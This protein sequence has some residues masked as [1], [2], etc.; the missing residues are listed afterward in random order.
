MAGRLRKRPGETRARR[1]W[2]PAFLRSLAAGSS[3][4][5]AAS[6]VGISRQEVYRMRREEPEFATD[7]DDAREEGADTLEDVAYQRAT[8]GGSDLLLI[9]LLKA[10][11]P[12]IYREQV[13]VEGGVSH[14]HYLPQLD[15]ML[16]RAYGSSAPDE[17]MIDGH[18]REIADDPPGEAPVP[19]RRRRLPP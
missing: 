17:T 6:A 5:A 12:E 4:T 8:E 7:M 18:S 19:R 2:E 16:A 14:N 10:K 9:F 13:R 1:Q 15:D 3:V 11:R